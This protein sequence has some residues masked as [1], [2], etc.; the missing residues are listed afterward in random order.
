MQLTSDQQN[1]LDSIGQF[2]RDDDQWMFYL[3]GYA[4]TG[5]TTLMHYFINSL[6]SPPTCLAPTGKAASVLAKRLDNA[7]VTTI[8]S[9]L[10]KPVI[11]DI[12]KLE[13]LER[14]LQE[15]ANSELVRQIKEEKERLA[16]LKLSFVDNPQ[17][18]IVPGSLVIVDEASMVNGDMMDKLIRTE[19]KVLF[20]GDPGQ[21]PPVGDQ[22]FFTSNR[23]DAMLSQVMRQALD[24]P[25]VELSMKIRK[26]ESIPDSIDNEHI[27]R[28]SRRG[29]DMQELHNYDQIL[30]GKNAIRRKLNRVMRKSLGHDQTDWPEYPRKG[31]RLIVLKNVH[32]FDNYL[33]NG[34]QCM[35]TGDADVNKC[36]DRCID[37]LYEGNPLDQV[38]FYHHP[39][40]V[41][42]NQNSEQDPWPARKHLVEMDYAYAVT[43][44]KSQ[45]S[46]W[47]AVA[48]VDD[49]LMGQD[50]EFRKRWLYTAVTRAK[51]RLL[52]IDMD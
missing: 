13:A 17:H 37:I 36:G 10:Y 52:W 8:H 35:S 18:S 40:E 11:P 42:Y 21:L 24:N 3:G 20:V 23:P 44:H 12:S 5:K 14:K 2:L 51:E 31:E 41:H 22:G 49:N 27:V 39:F 32:K 48:L 19:A 43:V 7:P 9:A 16:R 26:R 45:G 47:P 50:R 25:I 4:G 29:F 38:P 46:E 33:V 1:A 6:S 34:V 15:S 28:R 30:T